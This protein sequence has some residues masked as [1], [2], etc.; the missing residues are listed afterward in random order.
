[1]AAM[2]ISIITALAAPID[3]SVLDDHL[4]MRLCR[5]AGSTAVEQLEEPF[6]PS[7]P[8]RH[9][10]F[11]GDPQGTL[12]AAP[13]VEQL[14]DDRS[15][16]H[17]WEVP[18]QIDGRPGWTRERDAVLTPDDLV[19]SEPGRPVRAQPARRRRV[20]RGRRDHVDHA[21]VRHP[22]QPPQAPGGRSGNDQPSRTSAGRDA[23]TGLV[24]GTASESV[25]AVE[26]PFEDADGDEV[27]PLVDRDAERPQ[28]EIGDDGVV[29]CSPLHQLRQ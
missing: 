1:M 28:R 3:E 12:G 11:G 15:H 18:H 16:V 21:V 10:P 14:I 2:A 23:S 26:H 22:A 17:R 8:G 9:Q 6:G 24:G 29:R 7:A 25:A 5:S 4:E 13:F 20:A 27:T 19:F